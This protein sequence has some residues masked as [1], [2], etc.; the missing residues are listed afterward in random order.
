[1]SPDK[2]KTSTFDGISRI[3]GIFWLYSSNRCRIYKEYH[4]RYNLTHWNTHLLPNALLNKDNSNILQTQG[5]SPTKNTDESAKCAATKDHLSLCEILERILDLL[6]LHS[7]PSY[8][9]AIFMPQVKK[10]KLDTMI[11]ARCSA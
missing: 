8:N 11:M 6:Q 9:K 7:R 2:G 3:A 10:V 5:F 4:S 1:M